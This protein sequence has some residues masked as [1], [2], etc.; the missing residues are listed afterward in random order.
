MIRIPQRSFGSAAAPL[1]CTI[2]D[3]F[4]D[5]GPSLAQRMTLSM[6][7]WRSVGG[8]RVVSTS[9]LNAASL[10]FSSKFFRA[11]ELDRDPDISDEIEDEDDGDSNDDKSESAALRLLRVSWVI[12]SEQPRVGVRW[13]RS[14]GVLGGEL[15]ARRFP[16]SG[17]KELASASRLVKRARFGI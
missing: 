9:T 10:T 12:G 15:R 17:V 14:G 3:A 13:S 7:C 2:C 5:L 1:C 6:N 11:G 16:G 4:G 8:S